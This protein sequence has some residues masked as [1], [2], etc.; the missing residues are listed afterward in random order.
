MT[1]KQSN[2]EQELYKASNKFT[3][4]CNI[5]IYSSAIMIEILILTYA[6]YANCDSI[7]TA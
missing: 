4:F 2:I 6:D 7:K 5:K 1:V 3:F